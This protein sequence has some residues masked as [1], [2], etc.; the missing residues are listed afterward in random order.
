VVRE[1]ERFV[2]RLTDKS[3]ELI[4]EE[5]MKR[6]LNWLGLALVVTLLAAGC[7]LAG[8]QEEI[9]APDLASMASVASDYQSMQLV[10]AMGKLEIDDLQETGG[11][12]AGSGGGDLGGASPAISVSEEVHILPDGTVVTIIRTIDDQDTPTP[13]DDIVT[14]TRGFSIWDG[15]AER[16]E[17]IVRP[18][19]PEADWSGWE[20]DHLTQSGTTETFVEGV[21][22]RSGAIQATWRRDGSEVFLE[23]IV[24]ESFRID[25]TGTLT[26][27]VIE[28]DEEGSQVKTTYRVRLEGSDEVV[29]HSF[30][31]EEIEEEGETFTKITREDGYYLIVRSAR[32]PRVID[33]YS[34]EG[35]RTARQTEIRTGLELAVAWEFYDPD[36]N[37][38]GTRHV[39]MEF[40]FLGDEVLITKRFG[41]GHTAVIRIQELENGYRITRRGETYTVRFSANEIRLYDSND[42]LVATVIFQ[43]DG[44]W[45]VVYPDGSQEVV[46]L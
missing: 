26:R 2:G 44:S 33:H 24:R 36:G 46:E 37:I 12:A 19:P 22:V 14:V 39:Q 1:P 13:E 15:A 20:A 8:N 38:T 28:I 32:N 4:G 17:R 41:G 18:R 30:V 23:R 21:L 25:R 29:V 43:E 5:I 31:H 3:Y 16:V 45:L 7:F 40:H 34:P 27:I 6:T 35:V 42:A 9:P 11:T 10:A